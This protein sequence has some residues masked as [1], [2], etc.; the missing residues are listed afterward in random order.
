MT[1][2]QDQPPRLSGWCS[3]TDQ[4]HT[5]CRRWETCECPGDPDQHGANVRQRVSRPAE[6]P[7]LATR[8]RPGIDGNPP[9]VSQ[10]VSEAVRPA[11]R[12][13]AIPGDLLALLETQESA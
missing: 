3:P 6:V 5:G 1:A 2:T 9:D 10:D 4:Y 11:E 8:G 12:R 7:I 13:T